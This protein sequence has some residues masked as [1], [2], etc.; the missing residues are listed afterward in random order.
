M[1]RLFLG[2][3]S[4]VVSFI[5]GAT[6]V[7]SVAVAADERTLVDLTIWTYPWQTKPSETCIA[8]KPGRLTATV[9]LVSQMPDQPVEFAIHTYMG[10]P[11]FSDYTTLAQRSPS[12]VSRA[13]TG[14]LYCYALTFKGQTAD[15][16]S[17]AELGAFTQ[18]VSLRMAWA[19]EDGVIQAP[20]S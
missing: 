11:A 8:L 6:A 15:N 18:E 14:G 20:P 19:P 13:I 5:V 3:A 10:D 9:T 12:I 17:R 16:L 2:L 4:V 7:P 1:H